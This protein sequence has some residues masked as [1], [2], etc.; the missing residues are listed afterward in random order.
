MLFEIARDICLNI[1]IQKYFILQNA[2]LT[3][4]LF[5]PEVFPTSPS[6]SSLFLH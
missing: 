6:K 5:F 2:W 4:P 3:G 1:Q